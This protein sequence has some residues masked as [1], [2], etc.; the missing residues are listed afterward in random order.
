[1]ETKLY[2]FII[3]L[4]FFFNSFSASGRVV[5]GYKSKC[6]LGNARDVTYQNGN[7][8]TT[9]PSVQTSEK[10]KKVTRYID[11][12][13]LM[14]TDRSS[15]PIYFIMLCLLPMRS[16]LLRERAPVIIYKCFNKKL[17]GIFSDANRYIASKHTPRNS[18]SPL[19]H[20]TI[21]FPTI[22]S[23]Y[24]TSIHSFPEAYILAI[25]HAK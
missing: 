18:A 12:A 4:L 15:L 2:C 7:S 14:Q 5:G 13:Y 24:L 25:T 8:L 10:E 17:E 16:L 23:N 1:M 21:F 3:N 11:C 19:K 9:K 22:C 20:P 6:I